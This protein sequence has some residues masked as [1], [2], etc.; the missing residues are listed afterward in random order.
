MDEYPR[1]TEHIEEMVELIETLEEKGYAYR[2]SDGVYFDTSRFEDYNRLNRLNLDEIQEGARVEKNPEKRNPTD[3]VLWKY[4]KQDVDGEITIS[5][6]MRF[7]ASDSN[8][9][10]LTLTLT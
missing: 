8:N 5:G 6:D 10:E 9:D 2:I 1:A 4:R 3:F 7:I